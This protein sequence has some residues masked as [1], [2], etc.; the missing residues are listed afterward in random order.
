MAGQTTVTSIFTRLTTGAP[1]RLEFPR[2]AGTRAAFLNAAIQVQEGISHQL[3]ETIQPAT[4]EILLHRLAGYC[5]HFGLLKPENAAPLHAQLPEIIEAVAAHPERLATHSLRNIL[6]KHE[7]HKRQ[8]AAALR[9]AFATLASGDQPVTSL[10]QSAAGYQ[11]VELHTPA[12][13]KAETLVLGHCIG[14]RHNTALLAE[15]NI[16]PGHPDEDNY[17][18]Y[19][20]RMRRGASRIFSLRTP[21]GMPAVTLHYETAK[22]EITEI[23]TTEPYIQHKMPHLAALLQALGALGQMLPV[24]KIHNLPPLSA[25]QFLMADGAPHMLPQVPAQG[26]IAGHVK[27]A[28]DIR[29]SDLLTLLAN[30]RL[31]IDISAL[32]DT[33]RLPKDIKA[34]LMIFARDRDQPLD[35]SHI[36]TAADLTIECNQINLGSLKKC[37][38]LYL[39]WVHTCDLPQ[40]TRSRAMVL[41]GTALHAPKLRETGNLHLPNIYNTLELPEL[42]HA[43]NLEIAH[44]TKRLVKASLPALLHCV[45]LS[46]SAQDVALP[47]LGYT[48]SLELPHATQA[49]LSSLKAIAL[50][51]A[52]ALTALDAPSLVHAGYLNT[53]SARSA[54]LPR[55]TQAEKITI[56]MECMLHAPC[57]HAGTDLTRAPDEAPVTRRMSWGLD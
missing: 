2:D 42:R 29:Q 40:L 4:T 35:L 11:L 10:W 24:G 57:C 52:K 5:L 53:P 6:N 1:P 21:E 9:R 44:H 8:A 19:A 36:E 49:Q 41:G 43:H 55:L 3:Q 34:D 20:I 45:S 14:T 39:P 18:Q 50:L 25:G 32:E 26:L 17:L 37:D 54:N 28:A 56:H 46:C 30:P 22:R 48:D 7:Q 13:L 12:H 33:R 51:K 16:P 31:T 47:Q 23:E 38:Q 15:K 27:I